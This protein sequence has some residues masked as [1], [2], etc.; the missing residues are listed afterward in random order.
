MNTPENFTDLENDTID[1]VKEV[2]YYTF[3]FGLGF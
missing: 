1:I 2:R 3:F